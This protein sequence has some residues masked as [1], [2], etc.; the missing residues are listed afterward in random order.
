[1][2]VQAYASLGSGDVSSRADFFSLPPVTA[3]AK[4][5]D[6]TP[7]QILLRWAIEKGIHVIPKSKSKDRMVENFGVF[8]FSLKDEEVCAIDKC[9]IGKRFAWRHVDPDTIE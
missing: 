5:H 7:A 9:H 2:G 4:A 8:D 3:A 6:R 1:M